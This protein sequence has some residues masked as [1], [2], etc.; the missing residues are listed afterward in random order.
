MPGD[1]AFTPDDLEFIDQQRVARL[2]TADAAGQPHVVP[3]CFARLGESLYIG[4]D[5]K[6]KHGD[7][8]RLRRL[9]N[10]RERP[11]AV[12]LLDH[13]DE[14]WDHLRWLSIQ[15]RATI[16]ETGPERA[17]ALQALER[18]YPQYAAMGLATLQLP[19]I[20]LVPIAVTRWQ[21]SR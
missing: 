16:L 14:H 17:A 11:E 3:V 4:I 8:R 1:R 19:V 5:A 20:A 18:R 13:Y 2:A 21:A 7:P 10:L 15:T 12:L 9:R 6:P